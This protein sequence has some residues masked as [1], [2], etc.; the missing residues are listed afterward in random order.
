MKISILQPEIIRGDITH[1]LAVINELLGECEGELA[2]LAEYALTGSLVLDRNADARNWAEQTE[3]A[4]KSLKIPPQKALLLNR[5]S[6]DG[7]R[8]YNQSTLL[9]VGDYQRKCYPDET[10]LRSGILP[11]SDFRLFHFA[12]RTFKIIICSDLRRIDRLD[13]AGADFVF[14][15]FHFTPTN[16]DEVTSQVKKL[17]ISRDLPVL[18]ASLCSDKNCGH[19]SYINSDICVSLG[20]QQG[21]LEV[22]L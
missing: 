4:I 14:Y 15:I 17:S 2:V 8:I 16:H 18:V 10:E 13:T 22:E 5:L 6:L 21:I 19:S 1:N 3:T 20:D 7:R 12:D 11:G 9:P